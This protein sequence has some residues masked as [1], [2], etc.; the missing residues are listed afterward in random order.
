MIP[1]ACVA[2]VAL[3]LAAIA[4]GQPAQHDWS[5]VR[6]RVPRID[7]TFASGPTERGAGIV[8]GVQGADLIVATADHVVENGSG[9]AQSIQMAFVSRGTQSIEGATIVEHDTRLDLAVLRLHAP[10]IAAIV[11]QGRLCYRAP[12]ENEPVTTI[13]HPGDAQWQVSS[14]NNVILKE[15]GGDPRRFTISGKGVA[16]GSSG[17]PVLGA[18][19]CL[20]GLVS[21]TS[22]VQTIVVS[23]DRISALVEPAIALTLLGGPSALDKQNRRATFDAVSTGLNSYVFDL[24]GVLAMFRR[25]N[26]DGDAMKAT[27]DHYNASYRAMYDGRSATATTIGDQFGAKLGGDYLALVDWLDQGHKQVVFSRLEDTVVALR[28]RGKLTKDENQALQN[29]LKDLDAHVTESKTRVNTFISALRV[30][31]S[32]PGPLVGARP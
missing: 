28:A 12:A 1:R 3:W 8:V 5:D 22:D 14:V 4:P 10:D 26:L 13:G 21:Q 17:G 32:P 15:Y 29:A 24:E 25:Q 19:G 2:G 18:D 27:I 6:A 20:I 31:L 9:A 30:V 11:G 16:R 7:S 23:A